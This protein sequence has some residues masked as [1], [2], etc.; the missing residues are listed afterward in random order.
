[1]ERIHQSAARGH[2]SIKHCRMQGTCFQR[3]FS[4]IEFV[5]WA[6]LP[7]I[8][9]SSDL[10]YWI[11]LFID[12]SPVFGEIQNDFDGWHVLDG[13]YELLK[14]SWL[15]W[16]LIFLPTI[17]N[18]LIVGEG[19]WR[20]SILLY[21]ISTDLLGIPK[22]ILLARMV[23]VVL[24]S[25]LL[26]VRVYFPSFLTMLTSLCFSHSPPPPFLPTPWTESRTWLAKL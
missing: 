2:S 24:S 14:V 15:S 10:L 1:M 4:S 19:S 20:R 25:R 5:W 21:R 12:A 7:P 9:L 17:D 6:S 13:T 22:M 16:D 8:L 3:W 18:S 23:T 11:H 26:K